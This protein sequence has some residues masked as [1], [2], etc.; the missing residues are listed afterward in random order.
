[1]TGLEPIRIKTGLK[2]K[3]ADAS[4]V[5]TNKA[6]LRG[7]LIWLYSPVESIFGHEPENK[8]TT[9][10]YPTRFMR[11]PFWNLPLVNN[12]PLW[13]HIVSYESFC[14]IP[15]PSWN[16]S[17][18]KV[19]TYG[20]DSNQTWRHQRW[21]TFQFPYIIKYFSILQHQVFRCSKNSVY[22]A[23]GM[24]IATARNEIR[25]PGCLNKPDQGFKSHPWGGEHHIFNDESDWIWYGSPSWPDQLQSF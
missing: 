19:K 8:S 2:N 7:C 21:N 12:R 23:L 16:V 3:P 25:Y 14:F 1:M 22:T 11:P 10:S 13:T 5:K 6:P 9:P 17:F 4:S 20:S 18:I 15:A 24:C